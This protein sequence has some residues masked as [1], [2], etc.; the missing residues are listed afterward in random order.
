L[1]RFKGVEVSDSEWID[2]DS[3]ILVFKLEDA[4]H[5]DLFHQLCLDIVSCASEAT[6]EREAVLLAIARTWRWHHLL[7]GGGDSRLTQE[8][9]K[10]LIGELLVIEKHL[11]PHLTCMDAVAA[12]HGPLGAPKDFEIGHTC[13]EVKARRGA[14][15]PH[16]AISSESQ[17]DVSGVES[18]FLYVVDLDRAPEG[19]ENGFSLTNVATRIRDAISVPDQGALEAFEGLLSASG[20]RWDDDYTDT[21]WIEGTHRVYHVTGSFPRIT[22]GQLALGVSDVCYSISLVSCQPHLVDAAALDSKLRGAT[23]G[24]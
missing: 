21:M 8:E 5:R 14:A 3:R 13:I 2:G 16:I 24:I 18:L 23:D 15:T 17:L 22:A 7:R 20:F 12:W 6:T 11:L 4:A 10:G 19:T 9:Q 1:P